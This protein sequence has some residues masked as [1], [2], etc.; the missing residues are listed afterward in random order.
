MDSGKWLKIL[1][2]YLTGLI[3]AYLGER[4]N[5]KERAREGLKG[6]EKV[7]GKE[8]EKERRKK[9]RKERERGRNPLIP[10]KM[11]LFMYAYKT[12]EGIRSYY[13]WL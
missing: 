10:F 6:L 11:Y 7:G 9:K 13:R 3:S 2:S 4:K 1:N 12:E 8:G 5:R